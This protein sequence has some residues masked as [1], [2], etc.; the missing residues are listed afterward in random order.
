MTTRTENNVV[1]RTRKTDEIILEKEKCRQKK[2][3]STETS[4]AKTTERTDNSCK[5][6]K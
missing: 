6:K 3:R 2:T 5:N 4:A 1:R